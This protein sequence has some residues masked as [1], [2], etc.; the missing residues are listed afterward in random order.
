MKEK[1]AASIFF[2]IVQLKNQEA[3]A[4]MIPPRPPAPSAGGPGGAGPRISTRAV[5]AGDPA[6]TFPPLPSAGRPG[7][8]GPR[9]TKVLGFKTLKISVVTEIDEIREFQKFRTGFQL[10]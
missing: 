9:I 4:W 10:S 7:G 5:A 6:W 1:T 2:P 3:T 8:A